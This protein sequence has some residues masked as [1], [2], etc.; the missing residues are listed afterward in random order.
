MH[1]MNLFF[2]FFSFSDRQIALMLQK[3]LHDAFEVSG[4]SLDSVAIANSISF[5]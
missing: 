3:K 5:W 2:F 4:R 1:K